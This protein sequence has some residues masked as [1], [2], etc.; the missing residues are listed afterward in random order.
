MINLQLSSQEWYFLHIQIEKLI[1]ENPNNHIPKGI[2]EKLAENASFLN[3]TKHEF[4][5]EYECVWG[6]DKI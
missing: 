6:G 2:L 1:K 3:N 5:K 4:K